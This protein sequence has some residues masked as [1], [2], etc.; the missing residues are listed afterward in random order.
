[1]AIGAALA[2]ITEY[3]LGDYTY[4]VTKEQVWDNDVAAGVFATLAVGTTAYL[5]GQSIMRTT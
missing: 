4:V 1:M 5:F 2:A 3:A